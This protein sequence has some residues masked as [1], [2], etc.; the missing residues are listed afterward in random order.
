[1]TTNEPTKCPACGGKEYRAIEA[2]ALPDV[3]V[4][5]V[6]CETPYKSA[7]ATSGGG[8]KIA[9]T[10]GEIVRELRAH[11]NDAPYTIPYYDAVDYAIDRLKSHEQKIEW[12][13]D[14]LDMSANTSNDL[15][16]QVQAQEQTIADLT[17]RAEQAEATMKAIVDV[18]NNGSVVCTICANRRGWDTCKPCKFKWSGLPQDGEG[19]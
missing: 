3:D 17:A 7:G 11:C 10:T 5:C 6:K 15:E 16:D 14:L 8:F 18:V 4:I 12:Y 2:T 1:M 13:N 9:P 19:K